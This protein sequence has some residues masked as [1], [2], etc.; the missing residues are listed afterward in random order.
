MNPSL[1]SHTHYCYNFNRNDLNCTFAGRS[2]HILLHV[3]VNLKDVMGLVI[4]REPKSRRTTRRGVINMLHREE[5]CCIFTQMDLNS[6]SNH[7]QMLLEK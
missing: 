1:T 7:Q 2:E 6:S 5:L 4:I 3:K